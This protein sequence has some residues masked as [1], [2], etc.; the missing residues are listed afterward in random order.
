MPH[1][2]LNLRNDVVDYLFKPI[3]PEVL[4]AKVMVFVEL[5]L[6]GEEINHQSQRPRY[7]G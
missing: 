4:R 7:H 6:K 1:F 5:F 2:Y 3:V